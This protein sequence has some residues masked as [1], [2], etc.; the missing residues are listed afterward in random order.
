MLTKLDVLGRTLH[1]ILANSADHDE[2]RPYAAAH[3]GFHTLPK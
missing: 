2:L 3:M 1:V